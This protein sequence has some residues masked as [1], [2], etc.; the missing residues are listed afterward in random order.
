MKSMQF[1]F[2][3]NFNKIHALP[4]GKDTY[5]NS[6]IKLAFKIRKQDL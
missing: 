3:N 5:N 4:I 6:F 2:Q 1:Y